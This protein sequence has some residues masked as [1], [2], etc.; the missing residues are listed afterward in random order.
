MDSE[1]GI[2]TGFI[3]GFDNDTVA[4]MRGRGHN[5]TWVPPG[6]SSAQALRLLFN[7]TFEAAGEPRQADSGGFAV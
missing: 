5:V 7:G 6:Y 2:G 1:S 3:H 4:F